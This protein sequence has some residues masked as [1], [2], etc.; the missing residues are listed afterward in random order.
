MR[1][2]LVVAGGA[3]LLAAAV[4]AEAPATLVDHRIDALT[5]GRVRV[6]DVAGTV[7]NGSGTL[8]VLPYGSRLPMLW[9]IDALPLLRSRLRG[10]FDSSRMLGADALQAPSIPQSTFDLSSDDFAVRGLALTLPA[11]AI[12]RAAEAPAI[13]T[14]AGGMVEIR[15]DTFALRRGVF[16]GVF[17]VRWQ[18]A[19]LPGLRADV[20]LD[21]GDIRLEA[22][23][24]GNDI[25]GSLTNVGGDVDIVGTLTLAV[26]GAVRVDARL[27]P[28][29]GVD[30]ER[31]KAMQGVLS[32]IGAPDESGGYR[33]GWQAPG[34]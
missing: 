32:M 11:E 22:L 29:P 26:N 16:E 7:W 4:A 12:L 14:G 15:T 24:S 28:R 8:V 34:R 21:L 6:A 31:A 27:K 10:T 9:H 3:L 30:G 18:G 1:S 2:W 33:V 19:S 5:H 13:V 23:G 20:R 25:K 17:V